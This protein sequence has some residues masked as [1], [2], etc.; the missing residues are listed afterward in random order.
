MQYTA[1]HP[2]RILWQ[3]VVIGNEVLCRDIL[4]T[5]YRDIY[6]TNKKQIMPQLST[7]Y[8]TWLTIIIRLPKYIASSRVC[9]G[10]DTRS[11]R[12]KRMSAWVY[13]RAAC[14]TECTSIA[15]Q[16]ILIISKDSASTTREEPLSRKCSHSAA[17]RFELQRSKTA[18]K[19][20]SCSCANVPE[21]NIHYLK[22][23]NQLFKAC[24]ILCDSSRPIL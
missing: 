9:S 5:K 2:D 17:Q 14:H 23:L 21:M 18:F 16:P 3:N 11:N 12:F 15:S 20:V 7:H 24:T 10:A 19:I 13:D 1:C 6:T 8:W 22:F 4:T